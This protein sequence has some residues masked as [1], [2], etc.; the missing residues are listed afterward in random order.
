EGQVNQERLPNGDTRCHY[1]VAHVPGDPDNP[2]EATLVFGRNSQLKELSAKSTSNPERTFP[3]TE[4]MPRTDSRPLGS[5]NLA[6][7]P[8]ETL[9]RIAGHIA[10]NDPNGVLALRQTNWHLNA[11]ADSQITPTQRLLINQGQT[12]GNF[13]KTEI[14]SFL[15]LLPAR[16][17]FVLQHGPLLNSV[18]Y[19]SGMMM[20]LAARPRDKQDFVTGNAQT[21]KDAGFSGFRIYHV[22]ELDNDRRNFVMN[23]LATLLAAGMNGDEIYSLARKSA[24]VR[25]ARVQALSPSA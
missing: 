22:S 24:D 23:N 18:G 7:L 14:K 11:I 8:N 1:Q 5:S 12:L 17:E 21:L 4:F 6:T 25:N 20:G 16:Q 2:F 13:S 10:S 15:K 19:S 3:T 9:D